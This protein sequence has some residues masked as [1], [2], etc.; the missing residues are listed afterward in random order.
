MLDTGPSDAIQRKA[1]GSPCSQ[2]VHMLMG[3]R[4]FKQPGTN[5]LYVGQSGKVHC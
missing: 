1:K 4:K 3:E 2:G 5:K